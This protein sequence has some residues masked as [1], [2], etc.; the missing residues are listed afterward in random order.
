[1]NFYSS[2]TSVMFTLCIPGSSTHGDSD[3]LTSDESFLG[4][5]FAKIWRTIG[6]KWWDSH[7]P[8]DWETGVGW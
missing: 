8:S 7:G 2:A 6:K 1:M 5:K 3:T 4:C